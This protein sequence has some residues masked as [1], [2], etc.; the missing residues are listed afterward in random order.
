MQLI[1]FNRR[2]LPASCS[3]VP[4]LISPIGGGGVS[5][6]SHLIQEKNLS[7]FSLSFCLVIYRHSS[8]PSSFISSVRQ[9]VCLYLQPHLK[10]SSTF[11]SCHVVPTCPACVP[12]PVL[13]ASCSTF[14][15]SAPPPRLPPALPPGLFTFTAG[16]NLSHRPQVSS[17]ALLL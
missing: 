14:S 15:S 7:L 13:H 5:G 17:P 11:L 4:L 1:S 6:R 10:F 9:H 8:P 16:P 3:Q 12:L 2:C